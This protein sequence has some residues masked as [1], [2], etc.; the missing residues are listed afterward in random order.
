MTDPTSAEAPSWIQEIEATKALLMY[1]SLS[2]NNLA[3]RCLDVIY[4]LC[5]PV[6]PSNATSSASAPSQQPQPI[7]MPFADQLYNDPTFG[8]LFPDVNQDLN[9]SAGMDFSEWVNFAPTPHNDF[10]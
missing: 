9:V 3:G 4:R 1:P 8:S 5:A 10:T 2:N 7:Y 6:Y